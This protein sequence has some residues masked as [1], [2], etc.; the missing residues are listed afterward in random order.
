L[1]G[2]GLDNV[3]GLTG[4]EQSRHDRMAQVME[5]KVRQLGGVPQ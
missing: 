1:T 4:L 2:H 5:P 3:V